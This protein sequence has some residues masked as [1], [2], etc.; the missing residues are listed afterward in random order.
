[1]AT[2]LAAASRASAHDAA[3]GM[4]RRNGEGG[5]PV[6]RDALEACSILYG[7]TSVLALRLMRGYAAARAAAV[8]GSGRDQVRCHA[9]GLRAGQVPDCRRQ[10]RVRPALHYGHRA[11]Q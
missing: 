2:D 9:H 1:M 8:H 10:P 3:A 4:A 7:A 6:A 5:D 11:P